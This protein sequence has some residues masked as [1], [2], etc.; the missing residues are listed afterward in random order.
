MSCKAADPGSAGVALACTLF[1][2]R[3]VLSNAGT[4]GP[5]ISQHSV[6]P[7]DPRAQVSVNSMVL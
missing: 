2:C 7:V 6:S 5:Q 1:P 4:A 3:G